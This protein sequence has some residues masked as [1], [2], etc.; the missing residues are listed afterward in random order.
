MFDVIIIGTGFA[1]KNGEQHAITPKEYARISADL[2]NSKKE[3][4]AY[5]NQLK[6]GKK[7]AEERG[8]T[9]QVKKYDEEIGYVTEALGGL[10][11]ALK[12]LLIKIWLLVEI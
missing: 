8:D 5:L 4:E 9:E 2:E 12:I 3:T 1:G 6:V 7:G 10:E 11:N